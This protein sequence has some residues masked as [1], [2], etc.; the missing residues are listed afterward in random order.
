MRDTSGIVAEQHTWVLCASM[1]S[2]S[3]STNV[4]RKHWHCIASGMVILVG[5][6][7]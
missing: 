3:P 2:A 7:H 5:Q 6:I 4:M 1:A